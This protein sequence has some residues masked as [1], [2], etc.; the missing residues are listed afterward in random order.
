M[1]DFIKG[2][3]EAVIEA[4]KHN[5]RA[6]AVL[7][8]DKLLYS[9]LCQVH[10]VND[11]FASYVDA[12]MICGLRAFYSDELPEEMLF[13]VL[14]SNNLPPTAQEKLQ[15]LEEENKRLREKLSKLSEL[16]EE[17]EHETV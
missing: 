13:S 2:V 16:L 5:I 11:S 12:P 17:D 6:N 7:I 15:Y 10:T 4:E 8:N 1:S 9:K 14:E 3:R